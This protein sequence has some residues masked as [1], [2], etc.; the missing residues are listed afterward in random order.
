MTIRSLACRVLPVLCL[1]PLA[2]PAHAAPSDAAMLRSYVGAY[3]GSG[4]ISSDPPQTVRCR[5]VMTPGKGASLD[6]TGRCAA[7][8]VGFN[9]TGII[10]A[11]G[12]R[13]SATM[14]GTG[15]GFSGAG[16]VAGVRRGDGVV[17]NSKSHDTAQGHD[18]LITSSF[19]LSGGSVGIKFSVF[20]NK[21]GKTMA[22][23]IPFT[24]AGR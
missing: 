15:D 20:D 5:L 16:T 22:G 24:R 14:S 10:T 13:I 9:L 3:A 11:A 18:R 21:T 6:Y 7:G 19:S 2:A 4:A 8:G 12:G 23:S 17:F 1:V